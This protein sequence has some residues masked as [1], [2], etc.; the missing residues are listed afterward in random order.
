M[1]LNRE[2]AVHHM[3]K[4]T[5]SILL[6]ATGIANAGEGLYGKVPPTDAAFF[7]FINLS[8]ESV[9]IAYQGNKISTLK[10]FN[11]TSYGFDRAGDFEFS[12]NDKKVSLELAVN[13]LAT[14]IWE[15]GEISKIS[16]KP[17]SNKRKVRVKLYNFT[18][19]DIA[20]KTSDG[21]YV[22]VNNTKSFTVGSRDVN[23]LDISIKVVAGQSELPTQVLRLEREKV[24]SIFVYQAGNSLAYETAESLR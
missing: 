13:E 7:R 24:L 10:S 17:F 16:E 14:L 22:V 5:L 6:L 3:L 23:P 4:V 11:V 15:N 20:L 12:V 8:P 19:G 2:I 18:Q 21:K 9:E 1:K